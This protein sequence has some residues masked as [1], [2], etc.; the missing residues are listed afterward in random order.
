MPSTAFITKF[1]LFDLVILASGTVT[2][3]FIGD[4]KFMN[5]IT[6]LQKKTANIKMTFAA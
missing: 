2:I 3:K 4:M 6:V 5:P 1:I